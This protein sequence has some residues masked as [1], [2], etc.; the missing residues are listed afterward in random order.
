MGH[1]CIHI[2]DENVWSFESPNIIYDVSLLDCDYIQDLHI[3]LNKYWLWDD[4]DS[5]DTFIAFDTIYKTAI[6]D[7]YRFDWRSADGFKVLRLPGQFSLDFANRRKYP[8]YSSHVGL[9]LQAVELLDIHPPSFA[10][11]GS[12]ESCFDLSSYIY[13]RLLYRSEDM[14]DHGGED[15]LDEED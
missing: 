6:E 1:P 5:G 12:L 7:Q 14:I 3:V 15:Y 4:T 2:R 8:Y 11:V 13:S 10:S 9:A